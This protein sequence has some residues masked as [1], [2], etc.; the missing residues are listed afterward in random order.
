MKCGRA[1]YGS[2][3][4]HGRTGNSGFHRTGGDGMTVRIVFLK[5]IVVLL[6]SATPAADRW[7]VYAE[8]TAQGNDLSCWVCTAAAAGTAACT[9]K[10]LVSD[11]WDTREQA[12]AAACVLKRRGT[13]LAVQNYPCK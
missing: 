11:T 10:R 12:A 9:G 5:L 1:S 6:L 7:G 8:H 3:K 2:T 13:C 4:R